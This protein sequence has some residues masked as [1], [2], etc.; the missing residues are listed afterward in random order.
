MQNKLWKVLKIQFLNQSGIN[1]FL[2]EKDKKKKGQAVAVFIGVTVLVLM[3][4]GFS[5]LIGFGYGV[6]GMAEMIPGFALTMVSMITLFFSFVKTSGYLFAFQDYD[7][8]MS[9]P[10]SVKVI[11][12]GKFLYMYL[13]NLLFSFAV[14]LP[15]GSAYLLSITSLSFAEKL[16]AG[17]MWI[18]AAALAPLL[19]ITIASI[20]G[21]I[22][23]A[24]GSKSRFKVL[25]QVVLMLLF[26]CAVIAFNIFVNTIKIE[27]DEEFLRQFGD[28]SQMVQQQMHRFYPVSA[29]FDAAVNKQGILPF[30]GF[31]AVSFGVYYCFTV[32]VAKKYRAINSALMSKG[33]KAAYRMKKQK[34]HSVMTALVY[35]EWKRLLSSA[36]YLLNIGVGMLLAVIASVVCLAVGKK[37]LME[38]KELFEV[39]RACRY[40]VPFVAAVFLTM[41]CTTSVSLSLEGKNLWIL[42]SLPI[43]WKTILKGKMAFNMVLLLPAAFI[44]SVCLGITL[45][46]DVLSFL[47]FFIVLV[48]VIS[49]STVIGMFFNLCFQKYQWENETEV[50][51]QGMS[52]TLG[53]L[54]NMYF[55]DDCPVRTVDSE[56]HCGIF[57]L[58]DG[59]PALFSQGIKRQREGRSRCGNDLYRGTI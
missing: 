57:Y 34:G 53:I 33:K 22:A 8:L 31:V 19:P 32:L 14:M 29:L 7:L 50:V 24:I 51:K 45:Q 54:V 21:T 58:P 47:L 2:Y 40:A 26:L 17:L 35:K 38:D 4:A 12:T 52:V 6:M 28:V 42:L 5:F 41:S 9:L 36:P 55:C 15:M 25:I 39:V 11:V 49:F 1:R 43:S 44:C 56:F 23:A 46:L 16:A 27:D 20:F 48:A 3:A 30:T 13:N 10:L 59:K 18:V 37:M